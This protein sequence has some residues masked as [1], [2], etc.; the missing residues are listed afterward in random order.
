MD[1]YREVILDHY[2]YPRNFGH[3]DHPDVSS[4]EHNVSCGDRIR[5]EVKLAEHNHNQ[6]FDI[7]FSG[8][9]CAIS[10]A[11]ASLLTEKVKGLTRAGINDL[12]KDDIL[13]LLET[14]L[15]PTRLKCALLPLEVLQRTIRIKSRAITNPKD[16]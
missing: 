7:R 14:S 10:T 12:T 9:G 2:K 13:T 8:E 11:S 15:T 6:I 5:M 1:I 3:L 4:E 16:I